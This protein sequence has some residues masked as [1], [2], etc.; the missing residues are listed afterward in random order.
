MYGCDNEESGEAVRIRK[1]AERRSC[2]LTSVEGKPSL[3]FMS[4][5]KLQVQFQPMKMEIDNIISTSRAMDWQAIAKGIR[6]RTISLFACLRKIRQI[7]FVINRFSNMSMSTHN[8]HTATT[9]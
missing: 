9:K 1:R 5:V 6:T 7:V 8:R 2:Q 4:F 3:N